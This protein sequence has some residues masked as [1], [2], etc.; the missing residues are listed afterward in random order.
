MILS[1]I[2]DAGNRRRGIMSGWHEVARILRSI[3]CGICV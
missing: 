2:A 3:V 1:W